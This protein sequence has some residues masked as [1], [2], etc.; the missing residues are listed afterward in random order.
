MSK[1]NALKTPELPT[2]TNKMGEAAYNLS[3]QEEVVAT[4]LT[5]F[6]QK[7]Y[8]ESE[9]EIVNRIISSAEKCKPQFIAK[10][11]LYLR[12]EANMRSVS[13]LLGGYLAKHAK[14]N[15]WGKSF[16]HKLAVRPDDMAEVVAFLTS[17]G[18]KLPAVV[19]KGFKLKMEELD[20]YRIDKYKMSSKN[21]SL[22]DLVRLTHPK[23]NQ[24]NAEAYDR[25]VHGKSLDGLYTTKILDREKSKGGDKAEAIRVTLE[26]NGEATPV[27]NLVRNLRDIVLHTPEKADLVASILTNKEKIKESKMLPF[28]FA[29]AYAEVEKLRSPSYSSYRGSG[30]KF[31][32]EVKTVKKDVVASVLSSIETALELSCDNIPVFDGNTAILIDHSGSMRGDDGG[33]SLIS[34]FSSVKT[35]TIADV[36]AVLMLNAQKNVYVG[37][38]GDK[39]VPVKVDRSK[40]LFDMVKKT[41]RL[42]RTVGAGTENGIFLFLK[43]AIKNK[44]KV[45]NLVIFSDMVIGDGCGWYG[46][47]DYGNFNTLFKAFK[48]IN[49]RCNVVSVDLH[50][51]DGTSV[52]NAKYGVHQVAGWSEKIFDVMRGKG[53]YAEIIKEIEKI[54]LL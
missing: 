12:R 21:V 5:T 33:D 30:I 26:A 14:G 51:T 48:K 35:S 18:K 54:E 15:Q 31:E 41:N 13:H 17:D 1:Y 47:G 10:L 8:Y 29:S 6:V 4:T 44:K 23:V 38:F 34:Q 50:Q 2:E 19:R 36:F 32:D 37:L 42:G 16:Y 53:G 52:F 25:L 22:I 46:V 9:N 28:R 49:P 39:L 27:M 20:P 40:G 3:A 24:K 11:A 45:D 43:D 7:S